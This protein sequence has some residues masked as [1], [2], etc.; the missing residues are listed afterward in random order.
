[1]V[2]PTDRADRRD[3]TKCNRPSRRAARRNSSSACTCRRT[4]LLPSPPSSGP[5]PGGGEGAE[6]QKEDRDREKDRERIKT[7][8][9]PDPALTRLCGERAAAG[10]TTRI[11]S[12][13]IRRRG[14]DGTS[15]SG[16]VSW[17]LLSSDGSFTGC[18]TKEYR[19]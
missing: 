19:T 12:R 13:V 17:C 18:G 9:T 2:G 6:G 1:M 16:D 11:A 8:L 7:A 10:R 14:D 15:V 4:P 3:S 5:W